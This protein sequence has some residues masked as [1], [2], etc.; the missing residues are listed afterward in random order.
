[1]TDLNESWRDG[2]ALCAL[3]HSLRP[4]V[5]DLTYLQRLDARERVGVA[6]ALVEQ[7]FGVEPMLSA[8][9]LC[10]AGAVDKLAMLSYLAQINEAIEQEPPPKGEK[11]NMH[12]CS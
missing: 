4:A 7:E 8:D 6:L 9:D 12:K 5:C 10:E 2:L 3:I 1:M 11:H